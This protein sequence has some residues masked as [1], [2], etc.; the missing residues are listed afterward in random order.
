[1]ALRLH[2]KIPLLVVATALLSGLAVG[3]ADYSSATAQLRQ[4]LS[5][6]LS[7]VLAGRKLLVEDTL[8]GLRRDAALLAGLPSLVEAVQ[9]FEAGWQ[10]LG[11]DAPSRLAL[12]Y[13]PPTA[14]QPID[15]PADSSRYGLAHGRFHPPLRDFA[16][17]YGYRDLVL[18]DPQGN[19]VYSVA[20]RADFASNLL[21]GPYKDSGLARAFAA[22]WATPRD[23]A[24]PPPGM[25]D[26]V[27]YPPRGDQPT[28]FVAVRVAGE[29]GT[30]LATVVLELGTERLDRIMQAP[31]GL[32]STGHAGIVGGDFLAR[33][34]PEALDR[35]SIA[36]PVR[37]ALA[38][39]TGTMVTSDE[40]PDGTAAE[41]VAAYAPLDDPGLH[42]A[43]VAQ[44]EL[45]EVYAPVSSFRLRALADGTLLTLVVVLAGIVLTRRTVVVPLVEVAA[46]L[47][48]LAEGDRTAEPPAY[49]RDDEIGDIARSVRLFRDS[50]NE[51]DRL[52][53]EREQERHDLGVRRKLAEA[54]EA[55]SEGFALF[56]QDDKLVIANSKF[57][58]IYDRAAE[59]L[60]PGRTCQDFL[61]AWATGRA[62]TPP[63]GV[64]AWIAERLRR[65]HHPAGT[66]ERQRRDGRWLRAADYRTEDGG[67]VCIR[68]DITERKHREDAL[69]ASEERFRRLSEITFE[70]VM[71]ASEGRIVDHNRALVEMSG[72]GGPELVGM[73]PLDLLTTGSRLTVQQALA[74]SESGHAEANALRKD[75]TLMPVDITFRMV[76]DDTTTARVVTMRDIT[77]R[78]RAEKELAAYREHLE[79][80]VAERTAALSSAEERLVAAINAFNSGLALYDADQRL[81]IVN[82]MVNT[83]FMPEIAHL[84]RPGVPLRLTLAG[85]AA[86]HALPER[87]VHAWLERFERGDYHSERQLEN[88][89]WIEISVI[90]TRDRSTLFI[91]TDITPHKQAATALRLALDREREL[92][93]LQREFVSMTSHEFRT[94]LA[95]IDAAIQRLLRRRDK[96][97][98]A[99]FDELGHEIRAAVARMIGLI[100]AILH[101]S[102]VEAGQIRFSPQACDMRA[103]IADVCRRQAALAPRHRLVVDLDGLPETVTIDPALIDQMVTNLLSNAVK[104]SPKGGTIDVTGWREDGAAAF[105]VGDHGLGIP[106]D[107]LPRLFQRFFRARTSTGIAG[108]GIGLHLVKKLVDMHGGSINIESTEGSGTVITVRLPLGRDDLGGA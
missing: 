80:V 16:S 58:E 61:R 10:E 56:D 83:V 89:R 3:G 87:W 52:A 54:I 40:R 63:E 48:R 20:K 74:G 98:A 33:G 99:E 31:D 23:G 49:A 34:G 71:I 78:K 21:I 66:V 12:L 82:D 24:A 106:A 18:V 38:G 100:D 102:Q 101:S 28:A 77:E 94:P 39:A 41:M 65:F 27:R 93:Q 68:T 42:W 50:L 7:A 75:G 103:V 70:G 37:A 30:P 57:L 22:V 95:I 15:Q 64:E 5:E 69:R 11:K 9:G 79:D 55:I 67:T 1:M 45:A 105:S 107:D 29:S 73:D 85:M 19:V 43:L 72:Y 13:R 26:F 84:H 81:V 86:V 62:E 104:Y 108:T 4:A 53:A 96:L 17:L 51:R 90:R 59:V 8:A 91:M 6:R 46:A 47:R 36:A 60:K 88:G 76:T 32:G 97:A 92:G 35:R 25:V 44:A 14:G 2:H